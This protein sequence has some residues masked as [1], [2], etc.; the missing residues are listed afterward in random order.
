M[1]DTQTLIAVVGI[2]A[3]V[4]LGISAIVITIRYNRNVRITYAHDRVIALTD[5]ITQNFPNLSITYRDQSVSENLVLLKGYFINIGKKD[6]SRDMVEQQ[7]TIVVPEG[8]EWVECKVVESSHSLQASATKVDKTR[9]TFDTGLWKSKEYMKFE[10]LA[11]VPVLQADT[12]HLP[13]EPAAERLSKA[14]LFAHRI[15][16]SAKIDETLVPLPSTE[17]LT[18]SPLHIPSRIYMAIIM[19]LLGVMCLGLYQFLPT[20]TLAFTLTTDGKQRT[21]FAEIRKNKINLTD[22]TG[23][24]KAYSLSEFDA[25]PDK[26]AQNVPKKDNLFLFVGIVYLLFSLF[27]LL[28]SGYREIRNKRLLAIITKTK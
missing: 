14:L 17:R 9:V 25:I 8:Y 28:A 15:A 4:I 26:K 23:Y 16:D 13:H 20:G 3:T 6:I 24:R 19:L 22:N 21:V 7:I 18:L 12:D 5:D 27:M 11:K 2:I 10:A 1:I